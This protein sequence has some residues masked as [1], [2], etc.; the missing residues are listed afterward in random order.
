MMMFWWC[1]GNGITHLPFIPQEW[2]GPRQQELS[3]LS[4]ERFQ[5][6]AIMRIL[7]S[8]EPQDEALLDCAPPLSAFLDGASA[9]R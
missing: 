1:G 2:L 8:K 7:D 9:A 3:P 6:N 4:R 5:R